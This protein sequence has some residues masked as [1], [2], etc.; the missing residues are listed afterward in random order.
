[1]II[2]DRAMEARAATG[3]PVRVG[4]IGAGAIATATVR[5]IAAAFPGLKVVAVANRTIDRAA[6]AFRGAGMGDPTF[7]DSA[8]A[9]DQAM[10]RNRP[11]ITDDPMLV[12]RAGG[13]DAVIEA[14]GTIEPA[15]IVVMAALEAGKHVAL[16]NAELDGTVGPILQ[17]YARASGVILTGIDGDQPG[18]EMN[19]YRF[20][21]S[22]G[23]RP[24]VCGNIKGLLDRER[25]PETQRGFA[26]KWGLS[27]AMAT[28][29]ADG[30]KVSFEQ[31][32]VANATGMRAPRRGLYAWEHQGSVESLVDRYS[33]AELE[34]HGGIVDFTVGGEPGGGI[35]VIA[36][37][38][39]PRERRLLDLYKMG[40]GPL[41]CF[42]T[43]K[44]LGH[45][46][47]PLTVA[48]AVLLDDATIRPLGGPVV[49]VVATAKRD[50]RVG[51]VL[52]GIGGFMAFGQCDNADVVRSD[53]LLPMGIAQDGILVRDVAADVVISYEDV[54][55]PLDRVV[56]RLRDEQL[57]RFNGLAVTQ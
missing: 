9:L 28:S 12:A 50:L 54:R 23:M 21:K 2:V 4:V 27:P 10:A 33:L 43:P 36:T 40:Q 30:T 14:T 47:I 5:Q 48:R 51:E 3:N 35:Y 22:I 52:D 38:D 42:V 7:V 16:T 1:M 24:L 13:I 32:V 18:V 46:E 39:D 19:L 53:G 11:A 57:R 20:V 37:H 17:E 8:T 56:D 6:S 49:E 25:T 15:A 26:D 34:R 29:F 44:H 31:A 55:L 41:Y 45:F